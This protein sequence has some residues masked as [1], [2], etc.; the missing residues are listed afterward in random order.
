MGETAAIVIGVVCLRLHSRAEFSGAAPV[1]VRRLW[2]VSV[3]SPTKN[4]PA[5]PMPVL[6]AASGGRLVPRPPG[7][8]TG[9]G[10]APSKCI[11]CMEVNPVCSAENALQFSFPAPA[12]ARFLRNAGCHRPFPAGGGCLLAYLFVEWSSSPAPR[13]IGNPPPEQ[14]VSRPDRKRKRSD[15]SGCNRGA[16]SNSLSTVL[17]TVN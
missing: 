12:Q 5:T 1:P 4:S 3:L 15:A 11:A 17:K 16:S 8:S 6:L 13:A 2:S 9:G 14:C 7:R 10:S